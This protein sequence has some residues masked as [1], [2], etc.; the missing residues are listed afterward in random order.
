MEARAGD[1]EFGDA[2]EQALDLPARLAH[3][4]DAL[5][6]HLVGAGGEEEGEVAEEARLDGAECPV[7]VQ[8]LRRGPLRGRTRAGRPCQG[9]PGPRNGGRE[10]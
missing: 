9:I 1:D 8:L 3:R 2:L 5:C 10:L 7:P 4:A 6:E